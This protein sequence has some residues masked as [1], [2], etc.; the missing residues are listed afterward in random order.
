MVQARSIRRARVRRRRAA[1]R[2]CEHAARPL[3][4]SHARA[5][6]RSWVRVMRWRGASSVPAS[7]EILVCAAAR[8]AR[9]RAD[10]VVRASQ[11]CEHARTLDRHGNAQLRPG[12]D[13][14]ED[15][16]DR[17]AL[18]RAALSSRARGVRRAA[19]SA[20][21]LPRARKVER[22]E[23]IKGFELTKG[24]FVELSKSELQALD[25]VASD[26]IAIQEFVPASEGRSAVLPA[27]LLPRRRQG[28]RPRLSAVPR[29]ARGLR[30]GRDR[31]VQRRAA[32]STSC[33]CGPTRTGWRC[34]SCAIR[35]R[36]SRGARSPRFKHTKAAA[37]ELALAPQVIGSLRHQTFDPTQ[38]KDEVKARVR[39]LIASK[40]K[41]RR[42]HGASGVERAPVTDLM[43]ALKASLGAASGK[44]NGARSNGARSR[45]KSNG[46]RS[47]GTSN[48]KSNGKRAGARPAHAA[49]HR[50]HRTGRS[51]TATRTHAARAST[52]AAQRSRAHR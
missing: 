40:A 22:D 6:A 4:A 33:C 7:Y 21:R 31:G 5:A 8:C 44:S 1:A 12:F 26:E 10:G 51:R 48:G 27:S 34:T 47:P 38:Y 42:D 45:A 23:M 28:R 49:P 37:A 2:D 14:G 11:R 36:S 50:S 29:R 24:N 3:A 43:A 18:A 19:A 52:T 35:T 41:G 13:P 15:L 20:V 16:L 46:A 32:S 9:A 30:A 17:R 25:A 39:A